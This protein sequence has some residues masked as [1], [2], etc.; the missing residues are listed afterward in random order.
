MLLPLALLLPACGT[1]QID[2][3][4]APQVKPAAIPAL[5]PQAKQQ[6]APS[7]CLPTC[8][9]VLMKERETWR[10]MLIKAGAGE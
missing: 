1:K 5:L 9:N 10:S 6:P 3:P 7:W 8:S 4:E 2:S